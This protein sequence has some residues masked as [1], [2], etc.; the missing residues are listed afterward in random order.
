MGLGVVWGV[1]SWSRVPFFGGGAFRLVQVPFS[2]LCFPPASNYFPIAFSYGVL[3]SFT[4]KVSVHSF[5][6]FRGD[7]RCPVVFQR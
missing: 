5:L 3:N 1:E 6:R 4:W 2:L 7:V